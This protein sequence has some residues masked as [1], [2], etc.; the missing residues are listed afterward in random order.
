LATVRAFA[1][2]IA[3][4]WMEAAEEDA[5]ANKGRRSNIVQFPLPLSLGVERETK[6]P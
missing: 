1:E 3:L 2:A 4:G 6:H 5:T